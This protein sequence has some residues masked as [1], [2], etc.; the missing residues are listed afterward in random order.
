MVLSHIPVDIKDK[1]CQM[2]DLSDQFRLKNLS[3][4]LPEVADFKP[5]KEEEKEMERE[6]EEEREDSL[7]DLK[8]GQ[9]KPV[10]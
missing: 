10:V 2:T 6:E 3:E 7:E 5:G 8:P 9:C 1:K 4:E